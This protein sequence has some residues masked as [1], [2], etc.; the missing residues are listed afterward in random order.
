LRKLGV[1]KW[2][3][4]GNAWR[5]IE[6]MVKRIDATIHTT[7]DAIAESAR[8]NEHLTAQLT[9]IRANAKTAATTSLS[10]I[11]DLRAHL[12]MELCDASA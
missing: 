7:N 12:I 3:I 2:M 9:G 4:I 11:F 10:D 6:E 8:Q 1:N 5:K